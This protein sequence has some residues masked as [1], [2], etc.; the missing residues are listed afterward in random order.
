MNAFEHMIDDLFK[1]TDFIEK[2]ID[3]DTEQQ[4]TCICTQ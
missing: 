1:V 4:I 3:V 2:F